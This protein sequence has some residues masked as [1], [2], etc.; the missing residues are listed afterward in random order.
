M[1]TKAV[2]HIGKTFGKL[3]I[4]DLAWRINGKSWM[5][6][7]CACGAET[8]KPMSDIYQGKTV[9]CGCHKSA[10]TATINLQHG[11][12]GSQTYNSWRAMRERCERPSNKRF[13]DYGGRGITVCERWKSFNNFLADMGASNGLTIERNN[14]D[15]N[16]EPGN[17]C[18][19]PATDQA[20]NRRSSLKYR[21]ETAMAKAA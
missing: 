12:T 10:T 9:S 14:V 20:K 2:D 18:W 1:N 6:C 21:N 15:G 13:K 11:M 4:N 19:I 16:Y 7:K 8:I 17:C 5:R 3:T